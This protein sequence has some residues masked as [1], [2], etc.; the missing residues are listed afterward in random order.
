MDRGAWRATPWGRKYQTKPPPLH[1]LL[2]ALQDKAPEDCAHSTQGM[3][4]Q[5]LLHYASSWADR[6]GWGAWPPSGNRCST[7]DVRLGP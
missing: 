4:N 1:S 5:T 7:G 3:R 2:F 6:G